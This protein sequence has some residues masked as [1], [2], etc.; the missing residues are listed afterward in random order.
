MLG[1]AGAKVS[2]LR[3]R[4]A[5]TCPCAAPEPQRAYTRAGQGRAGRVVCC[6]ATAAAN[7]CLA[8]AGGADLQ[9]AAGLGVVVQQRQLRHAMLSLLQG[10]SALLNAAPR[11]PN[12]TPLPAYHPTIH[13]M[14][15]PTTATRP[16]AAATAVGHIQPGIYGR[17]T[18]PCPVGMRLGHAMFANC[19]PVIVQVFFFFFGGVCV[20][21]GGGRAHGSPRVGS[22]GRCMDISTSKVTGMLALAAMPWPCPA[23]ASASP[24]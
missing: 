2:R 20:C 8:T 11:N 17:P 3:Y 16:T 24:L 7:C 6:W 1:W 4:A 9:R 19:V 10:L 5:R 18:L 23:H 22:V 13:P 14:P 15:P 21:A 12:S